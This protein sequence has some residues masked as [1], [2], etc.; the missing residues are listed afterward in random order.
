MKAKS[1]F[2]GKFKFE[3][4]IIVGNFLNW[5]TQFCSP[6]MTTNWPRKDP[7]GAAARTWR[8]LTIK[9]KPQSLFSFK[10]ITQEPPS[11]PAAACWVAVTGSTQAASPQSCLM[12]GSAEVGRLNVKVSLVSLNLPTPVGDMISRFSPSPQEKINCP[13]LPKS[14]E[15]ERQRGNC[16]TAKITS[17]QMF[18]CNLL[19]NDSILLQ[20]FWQWCQTQSPGFPVVLK[21]Y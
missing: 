16:R 2:P 21:K 8:W 9:L 13:P 20:M 11:S 4:N 7:L 17:K 15:T 18:V 10:L 6:T 1:D 3:R 14:S 5:S 19:Q 12:P